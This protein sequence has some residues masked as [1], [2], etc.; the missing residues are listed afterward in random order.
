MT[1]TLQD[2]R[3]AEE[4]DSRSGWTL[5]R[6]QDRW[7][8][9]D[10]W[11]FV[12]ALI[13]I[14][15]GF[16][17]SM[18]AGPTLAARHGVDPFYYVTRQAI[19]AVP[20]LAAIVFCSVLSLRDARRVGVMIFLAAILMLILLPFMGIERGGAVRWFSLAGVSVQP[21]EFLKPGL[22]VACGWMMTVRPE[23]GA[24]PGMPAAVGLLVLSCGLLASQPDWGQT[25]LS[26]SAWSAMF[27]L[28]GASVI[29]AASG[30]MAVAVVALS[31]YAS[32]SHFRGRID[33]FLHSD[34]ELSFQME[35]TL[36]AIRQGGVW[37]M[38][39][40]EGVRK[41]ALPDAHS[42]FIIA[43]AAEEYGLMLTLAI[44]LLF[45][46][47]TLK[48]LARAAASKD[49]FVR[50]TGG[51]L[52]CLIGFQAAIHVGVAVHLLPTKGMTLPFVSYGGSSMLASGL[53]MGLLL[54]LTRKPDPEPEPLRDP[55]DEG[56]E[57]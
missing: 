55:W 24:P 38:G 48:S 46:F 35:M 13:L 23:P 9:V 32:S 47:I 52:A 14:G 34:G 37:G 28:T 54:A 6:L 1:T 5:E 56:L 50:V 31:A 36:A 12:A 44:I 21:S 53:T 2:F 39:P 3:E 49:P 51:G 17:L 25:A 7:S 20:A 33:R 11:S 22:I 45:A 18:S 10:H 27:F 8:R 4:L 16:V 41:L 40:G 29:W 42:D 26:L 30:A 43:V 15:V 19:Y 57:R